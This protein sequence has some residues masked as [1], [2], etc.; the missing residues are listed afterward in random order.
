M[1]QPVPATA[2]AGV[3]TRPWLL[4]IENLHV[5]FVTSRGVVRAVEGVSYKVKPG[6]VV[7]L[8]GE[9]GCGK[10][11]S[12][13]AVMRLLAKPAGRVVH[14]RILFEG[15]DLLTLPDD[16]MRAIRGRD[17]AMI[18]QEPMTSLNPVLT[19]GFQIMEPLLI[20]LNMTEA[21]ARTRAVELLTLVGIPDPDRRLDQYPHQ[22][23]GGMRQRVMIA[24]GLACNP[25]LIIADEP[26][27]A[28][29]VTIQ[30]QIL[31]LMKKLSR[32]LNIALVVI[33]HNLGIVAR[34]ADRVNVMYAA[35][36][37]E[38]GRAADVFA[39]PLHPYTAG[40]LRSVPRLDQ[41]RGRMLETIEGLPPNLLEPPPGC[42]FAP[43]C[44]A[45]QDACVAAVPE[46]EDVMPDRHSA[47]IRAREMAEV[48]AIG[49]G[50]QS[51]QPESPVAKNLDRTKPLL[52]VD[53]LKT[54]FD[55]TTGFK[56]F[57]ARKSL[58]RAVDD[59]SIKIYRGETVGLVGESGC[60][61]TTVGRTLL[62]LE[63]ATSGNI[64]F[65]G[66]DVVSAEGDELKAYRRKVQVIFQDPYS[67]LNPRMTIGQIIAEPMLVYKLVA[68]RKEAQARV[69][70]L[71]TQVGLFEYMAERYP[72]ELSGGQ[73][74]R[75]G[76]ARAL[77]MEPE[78]IIC[79][80]PVSAL[81]VSI[82]AQIINLLEELQQKFN[83]TFLFIAHDLAVVRH[84][85]NRVIVMYLGKVMEIADRDALYANP[86]HPYTQ[87]LLEAV[88]IPDPALEAQRVHK[89]IGGEVPSPLN[90]PAGCVFHTRC[91]R[92]TDECKKGV[93]ELKEVQPGHYAA[94]I[95]I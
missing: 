47:C 1:D 24:I 16:E 48:G 17:I 55:V 60:G 40:L 14:G 62:R 46:L 82:Q 33:T 7:A 36:L 12:S 56:A 94:C 81:D 80:E 69:K 44:R 6:E 89:V 8:V 84:I 38:T 43:R 4:E 75:V 73:R 49:L 58:V 95:K 15:R 32:E 66:I 57:G 92:A 11:V 50:L 91:P 9:S 74:Q 70:D 67:S 37:A 65:D 25:K 63:R 45:R 13:L 26:T 54:Y 35:R 61:K 79:D 2:A 19:I 39:Q 23:S 72:H 34:Y 68:D 27:T 20:H 10:S 64:Q 85:S 5:H 71:L 93:P 52:Q 41:P 90:P 76:I 29:D 22:F 30:A 18:F 88:P 86:L 28:L 83:L 31:E 59:L 77:A 53:R 42:R 78:F 51:A 21:Q 3:A 87:A